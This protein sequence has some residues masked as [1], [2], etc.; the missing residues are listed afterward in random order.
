MPAAAAAGPPRQPRKWWAVS[1][2]FRGGGRAL[3]PPCGL[4]CRARRLAPGRPSVRGQPFAVFG[5]RRTLRPCV[6]RATTRCAVTA[7]GAQLALT[8][9]AVPNC[10]E[11]RPWFVTRTRVR[12]RRSAKHRRHGAAQATCRFAVGAFAGCI[13]HSR[14]SRNHKSALACRYRNA[15]FLQGHIRAGSQTPAVPRRQPALPQ[16]GLWRSWHRHWRAAPM[17]LCT[18][19]AMRST[20]TGSSS[21]GRGGSWGERR[22]SRCF[23][24]SVTAANVAGGGCLGQACFSTFLANQVA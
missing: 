6:R 15:V 4:D 9:K 5:A 11:S 1:A 14:W 24:C 23:T 2:N 22:D 7:L 18:P 20:S 16:A 10:A 17:L 3:G 8:K 13:H 21:L 12:N 19:A